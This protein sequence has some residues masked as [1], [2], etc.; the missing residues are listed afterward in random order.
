ME[1][2]G[3]RTVRSWN[4]IPWHYLPSKDGLEPTK[5]TSTKAT[6]L[7]PQPGIGIMNPLLAMEFAVTGRPGLIT[8]TSKEDPGRGQ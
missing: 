8:P 2:R 6:S 3:A 4:G 7:R 5:S 1:V